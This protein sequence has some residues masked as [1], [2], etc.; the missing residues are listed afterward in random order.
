[1]LTVGRKF[2]FLRYCNLLTL[3]AKIARIENVKCWQGSRATTMLRNYRQ[4]G[5]LIGPL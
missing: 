4:A 1:M 5:K 3:K 2:K